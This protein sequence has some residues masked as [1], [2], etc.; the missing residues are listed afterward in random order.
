MSQ[1]C[2]AENRIPVY[3]INYYNQA[4]KE[5]MIKRFEQFGIT[6]YFPPGVELTDERLIN[7]S[8]TNEKRV[9]SIMLQHL[10]AL[11][12]FCKTTNASK[13]IVAEDDIYISKSF[14]SDLQEII[15]VFDRQNLDI[16]LLGYL[17]PFKINMDLNNQVWMNHYF[18]I[19]DQSINRKYHR[20]PNDLWGCQMYLISRQHAQFLLDKYTVQYALD[21]P[22]EPYNPDWIITKTGNRAIVNPMIAVEEG[23]NNSNC[24]SQIDFHQRCFMTNYDPNL[25]I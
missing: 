11:K 14:S 9:W 21:H 18:P 7:V 8:P 24:H 19:I 12:H 22:N 17:L 10:D 13:C 20:Y 4:R 16:L 1:N 23:V 3:I 6:P 25:Y 15:P 2:C 5:R